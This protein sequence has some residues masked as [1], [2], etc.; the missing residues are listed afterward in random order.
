MK[1]NYEDNRT[2]MID[3]LKYK[4]QSFEEKSVLSFMNSFAL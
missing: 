3:N 1:I 2:S 4:N